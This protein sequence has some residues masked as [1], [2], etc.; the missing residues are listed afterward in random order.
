MLMAGHL[1]DMAT[2]LRAR[3]V[4]R[5]VD[6][7]TLEKPP[8]ELLADEA[9][10]VWFDSSGTNDYLR[11]VSHRMSALSADLP[12]RV[13]KAIEALLERLAPKPEPRRAVVPVLPF[14]RDVVRPTPAPSVTVQ[15]TAEP[16]S[17]AA[18]PKPPIAKTNLAPE[19]VE[20]VTGLSER[21]ALFDLAQT[22]TLASELVTMTRERGA[23]MK[24]LFRALDT[25]A[26]VCQMQQLASTAA[27][28][29][30]VYKLVLEAFDAL[31]PR[32][33]TA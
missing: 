4:E 2:L 25:A 21:S 19:V 20:V 29:G 31:A 22:P 10:R 17:W 27:K 18:R 15:R 3:F 8:L 30:I 26:N 24:D 6:M 32:R 5:N 11:R 16:A 14:V 7:T 13:R 28:A 1:A 23:S 9:L 12:Y 33:S